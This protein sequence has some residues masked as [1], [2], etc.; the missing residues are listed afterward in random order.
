MHRLSD[1][2]AIEHLPSM[3]KA[4]APTLKV[5]AKTTHTPVLSAQTVNYISTA[6]G[7]SI[8]RVSRMLF[9]HRNL[10]REHL[11]VELKQGSAELQN[12]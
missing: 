9:I 6:A 3:H 4:W 12:S 11:W 2:S 5:T 10:V 8:S 1:N 7:H